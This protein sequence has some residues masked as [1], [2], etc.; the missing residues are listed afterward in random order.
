MRGH[1]IPAHEV[2]L[3]PLDESPAVNELLPSS[4]WDDPRNI[5]GQLMMPLGLVDRPYDQRR[6]LLIVD[7]SGATGNVAIVGGPQSGKSTTLR[8]MVMAAAA[9]HTP[10]QLQF[11]CLDFGGGTLVS[12]ANLPH[13][14]GV[15]GRM[16]ADRMRRTI[17]EVSG[18][19]REREQRFRDL[20]IESMR[21]FRQ[22]KAQLA[23]MPPEAAARDPLSQD[24]FGDVVLVVD[25]WA[26]IKSDFDYLEPVL[27]AL[28]I[29]G[30]SYGIHL[31]L[32][33]TRWMEIRPAV[34]DMLGTRIELRM[35]DPIDSD[36]GR[37]FAELVPIGRPGRGMTADRLH[38]LIG[39]PRLDSSSATDDL[40]AGV[41]NSVEA[42]SAFYGRRAA[43]DVR[44]LPHSVDR[45]AVVEVACKAGLLGVSQIVIGID[46]A[47][48]APVVLRFDA[49]P[50]LVVFGDSECG[51]TGLLRNIAQG[52]MD[53]ATPSECKIILIDYQRSM[54]GMV[55]GDY[56]GGYATATPS[57]SELV[58]AL[59]ESLKERL[60]P[61]DIT[62]QQLKER[63]WWSGP[64][65]YVLIDDYDLIGGNSLNH[66]LSPLVEYFPLA[67][68][69]GLRTVITR[70]IGG[71]ARAMMDP[72][73]GRLKGLSCNGLVMSGSKDEGGLFGGYKPT[74]MPP[75]RGML[76]S[77]T[78][79]SGVI[80]VSRMPDP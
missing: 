79:K 61:S 32:S 23:A 29:Q 50:H 52:I 13:V 37:K 34:K 54:L 35:G 73:I 70:R 33:A 11:Y 67:R 65:V 24:K 80:Q 28:A 69:I 22:R 49:Q 46:E 14:G 1:G 41:A 4:S 45:D 16:D 47:E 74:E 10:E 71:A 6:D 56:I 36:V 5:N 26:T 53:T 59:A 44:M 19:L 30:L 66:P 63:S 40:P 76:L 42:V 3:P 21:D 17:A 25:G 31:A 58:T 78:V 43:P 2:W 48:L 64:D 12:L 38:M 39:L 55:D 51:K 7:L 68:D 75:G 57:C 9:T 77:R 15:A 60:P 18:L 20:G 62:P 27:Q 8:A 72:V